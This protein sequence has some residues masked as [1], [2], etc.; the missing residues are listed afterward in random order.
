VYEKLYL[1]GAADQQEWWD[2][3]PL[4][5]P[6]IDNL[7]E[8]RGTED[9]ATVWTNDP[10][11]AAKYNPNTPI[12]FMAIPE[13]DQ[14]K[15]W[16]QYQGQWH[17]GVGLNDSGRNISIQGEA[18]ID[19]VQNMAN[20]L[21]QGTASVEEMASKIAASALAQMTN[22]DYVSVRV[23]QGAGAMDATARRAGTSTP[24]VSTQIGNPQLPAAQVGQPLQQFSSVA[25][26]MTPLRDLTSS[27]S[28]FNKLVPRIGEDRAI[29][30]L[31]GNGFMNPLKGFP[32]K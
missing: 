19:S 29:E 10:T 14:A 24:V 12:G 8:P 23:Q 16:T 31:L 32:L 18:F 21:A 1:V 22:R 17:Q 26:K 6:L 25:G 2:S 7:A 5:G 27:W 13:S 28:A 4:I 9:V 30:W 15:Y 11:E 3:I 20:W